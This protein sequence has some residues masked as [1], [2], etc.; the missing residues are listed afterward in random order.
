MNATTDE[1]PPHE[2]PAA[3]HRVRFELAFASALLAFGLFVLPAVIYVVGVALLGPYGENQGMGALY[4]NF[5]RDL[6][7]PSG[8]TWIIALGP[9]LLI[10]VAR[11]L[12]L[13]KAGERIE[14]P[15]ADVATHN[16]RAVDPGER[17]RIEPRVSGD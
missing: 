4:A 12:W 5:F 11:L 15:Q 7:K 10:S 9:L 16:A 1:L 3:R 17:K 13:R 2:R 8:R 6:V 14:E